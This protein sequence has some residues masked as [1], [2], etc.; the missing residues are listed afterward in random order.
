MFYS[1]WIWNLKWFNISENFPVS[2]NSG[3]W[4]LP[5]LSTS[6]GTDSSD[7]STC[8]SDFLI[9]RI[10]PKI[11]VYSENPWIQKHCFLRKR[12][13]SYIEIYLHHTWW[14][15]ISILSKDDAKIPLKREPTI[16]ESDIF[17][18]TTLYNIPL[19]LMMHKEE[20]PG[21]RRGIQK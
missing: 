1:V 19:F 16:R 9:I 6:S 17:F 20:S 11:L 3:S 18:C 2:G 4:I 8:L 14:R 15:Y 21:F 7:T 5:S 13:V 10:M 12:C